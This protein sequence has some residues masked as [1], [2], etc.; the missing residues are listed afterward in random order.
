MSVCKWPRCSC[1]S[2]G[3]YCK[4]RPG[5]KAP[6]RLKPVSEK[7]KAERPQEELIADVD[8][9]FYLSVWRERLKF[10]ECGCGTPL[11]Y[12]SSDIRNFCFHHLLP[13]RNFEEYRYCKWNIALLT[14][15]CHDA[16]ERNPLTRPLITEKQ[17]S[18]LKQ[19]DNGELRPCLFRKAE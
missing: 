18:L 4:D 9:V 3:V 8:A 6:K 5:P 12:K 15:Q 2:T 14:W 16:W 19:H 13:K 7:K 10:C 1:K 17:Q 11:F